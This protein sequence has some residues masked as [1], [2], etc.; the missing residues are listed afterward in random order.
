[1]PHIRDALRNMIKE[2]NSD[3]IFTKSRQ[4]PNKIMASSL[5]GPINASK[6]SSW[7]VL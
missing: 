2:S 6:Y 4:R 1:M 7:F 3:S 5:E